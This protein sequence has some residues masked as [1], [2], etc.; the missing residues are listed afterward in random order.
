MEM[1][2]S[3]LL[4]IV[5]AIARTMPHAP[6]GD[7]TLLRDGIG[8]LLGHLARLNM[9]NRGCDHMV[10]RGLGELL[11]LSSALSH[12]AEKRGDKEDEILSSIEGIVTSLKGPSG[13]GQQ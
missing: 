13:Y 1:D 8:H 2:P 3:R 7:K 5:D 10:A 9:T 6:V 11:S 4:G 12:P